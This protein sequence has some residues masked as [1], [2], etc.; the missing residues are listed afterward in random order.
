MTNLAWDSGNGECA[1]L[2]V[3][4]GSDHGHVD[5]YRGRKFKSDLGG[6]N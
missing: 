6:C 3:I 2:P 5:H 4:G 1:N